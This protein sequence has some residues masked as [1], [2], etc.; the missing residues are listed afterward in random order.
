M[1]QGWDEA[2]GGWTLADLYP[3]WFDDGF[4]SIELCEGGCGMPHS[5]CNCAA[6]KPIG[7]RPWP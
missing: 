4:F 1:T 3:G 7:N 6:P 5:F 2:L